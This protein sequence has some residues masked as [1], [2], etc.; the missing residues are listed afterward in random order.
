VAAAPAASSDG[1][2]PEEGG[3]FDLET[4]RWENNGRRDGRAVFVSA[5]LSSGTAPVLRAET[6]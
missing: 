1:V 4:T 5:Q 6:P 3:G 2:L